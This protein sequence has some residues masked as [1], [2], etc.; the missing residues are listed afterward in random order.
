MKK[1]LFL[2]IVTF[3]ACS[4]NKQLEQAQNLYQEAMEIH[5]AVMPRMDEMYKLRQKL[6]LKLDS[7]SVDTIANTT[8]IAEYKKVLSDLAV[9][10]KGMMDWMHNIQDVPG[11]SGT[12]AQTKE[13]L[14]EEVIKIQQA[15]KIAVEQV[16]NKME[17]CIAEGKNL[18]D[19]KNQ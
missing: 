8:R 9:A 18:I 14:I 11:S 4:N 17:M 1:I 10:E 13:I 6:T 12:G 3:A 2:A 7:I 16:R 15:Q 5:D 19:L